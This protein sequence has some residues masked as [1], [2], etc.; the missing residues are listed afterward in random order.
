MNFCLAVENSDLDSF[1][2]QEAFKQVWIECAVINPDRCRSNRFSTHSAKFFSSEPRFCQLE[3]DDPNYSLVKKNQPLS[4]WILVES[5]I[6][7]NG[8]SKLSCNVYAEM[9]V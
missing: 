7:Q 3:T 5:S 4:M 2:M 6:A 9:R 8:R 1:E